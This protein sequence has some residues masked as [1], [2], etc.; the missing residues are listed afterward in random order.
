MVVWGRDSRSERHIAAHFSGRSHWPCRIRVY[1]DSGRRSLAGRKQLLAVPLR[2]VRLSL[3]VYVPPRRSRFL[4]RSL[5]D[6]TSPFVAFST[7]PT[8]LWRLG[9]PDPSR[10]RLLRERALHHFRP[11]ARALSFVV[12]A[13]VL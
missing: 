3:A 12:L 1:C 10:P 2:A 4:S 5:C 7:S 13:P 6:L 9:Y 8:R 11:F